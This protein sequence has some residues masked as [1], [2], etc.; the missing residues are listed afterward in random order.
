MLRERKNQDDFESAKRNNES[1][2]QYQNR[3]AVELRAADVHA[4]KEAL[5]W[6]QRARLAFSRGQEDIAHH[7][8]ATQLNGRIGF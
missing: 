2:R 7:I 6:R 3:R 5:A 4:L 8:W 1:R